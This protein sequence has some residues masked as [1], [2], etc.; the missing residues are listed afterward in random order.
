[1]LLRNTGVERA[2]ISGSGDRFRWGC[3]LG[4]EEGAER[5]KCTRKAIE[6]T[7]KA[8]LDAIGQE[9]VGPAARRPG[10]VRRGQQG[11]TKAATGG[12]A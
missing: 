3:F 10:S 8:L 5:G 12:S 11:A 9:G 7:Q 4:A 6:Q 1:M 2:A